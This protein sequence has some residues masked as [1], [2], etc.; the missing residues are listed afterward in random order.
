MR[1]SLCLQNQDGTWLDS[2]SGLMK[3]ELPIPSNVTRIAQAIKPIAHDGTSQV[4]YY[5][6]LGPFLVNPMASSILIGELQ[7]GIGSTGSFFARVIG[8]ATA[9]G[10]SENIRSA[11]TFI[12]NKSVPLLHMP[13]VLS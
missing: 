12:A 7:A 5:Q 2:T 10:L 6:V 4:V 1:N 9:E 8:G 3:G 13:K 11:Y